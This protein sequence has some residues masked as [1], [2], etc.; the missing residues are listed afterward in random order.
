MA[1]PRIERI[2][3][4]ILYLGDCYTILPGLPPVDVVVTDPPYTEKTHAGA[5]G[6][7]ATTGGEHILVSFESMPPQVFVALVRALIDKA[8]R[9]VVATCDLRQYA[10]AE[11]EG[12]PTIRCGAWVKNDPAPQFSGDRPASGWEAIGI[13]HREGKKRWNGGGKPA[14]WRT[15]IEKNS[16]EHPTQKPL[17]LVAE[18]VSAFSDPG[19]TV[20]DPFM[21][22][23]T[24]GVAC[25]NL[26]RK[27]I[28]I[29]KDPAYFGIAC[30]RI[31]AAYAQGRLFA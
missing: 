15:N 30:A 19:E 16:N 25:A 23:G 2:G 27:F 5:R 22:S 6:R 31:R 21:G 9:W 7:G 18:L 14:V 11:D 3:D 13:F 10:H 12:L 29:E 26:G 17:T 4:A 8:R 20:L 28:G 1:E 24:T